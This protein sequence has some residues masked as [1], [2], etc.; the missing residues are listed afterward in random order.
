MYIIGLIIN[1]KNIDVDLL[2]GDSC[3]HL[4]GLGSIREDVLR[5]RGLKPIEMCLC[6][7]GML[8]YNIRYP[9]VY[10]WVN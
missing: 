7:G 4:T 9:H 5:K 8:T 3:I 2:Y 6:G 10:N 1:K